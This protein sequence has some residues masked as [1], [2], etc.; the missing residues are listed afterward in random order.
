M[1]SY[2]EPKHGELQ[3][4]IREIE[5][6]SKKNSLLLMMNSVRGGYV[7]WIKQFHGFRLTSI[8]RRYEQF[9]TTA[10]HGNNMLCR[11]P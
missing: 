8:T 7:V 6:Y 3:S 11:R 5:N 4:T 1:K 10:E 9:D 2:R